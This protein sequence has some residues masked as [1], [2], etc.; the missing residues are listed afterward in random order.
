MLEN[1]GYHHKDLYVF[2]LYNWDINF[3]EM[4]KKRIQCWKWG[5]Q[6]ADCRFRPLN[7]TFDHYNPRKDQTGDDYYIRKQGGWTDAL[8]KEFR[9]NVRRQNIAVRQGYGYYSHSLERAK[10][11]NP[12]NAKGVRP[13]DAWDPGVSHTID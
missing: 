11:M 10:G 9:R 7:Q 3:E 4:E 6:I 2:M 13:E 5:V 8:I 1:A 12:G